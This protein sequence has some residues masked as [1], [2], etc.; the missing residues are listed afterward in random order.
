MS[1]SCHSNAG[2]SLHPNQPQA[3]AAAGVRYLVA[4]YEADAQLA[5]LSMKGIVDVV[6]SEDSDTIP[7]GCRRV[8]WLMGGRDGRSCECFHPL[9]GHVRTQTPPAVT[10]CLQVLFKLD[11]EGKGQEIERANLQACESPSFENWT[12]NMVRGVA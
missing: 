5:Y 1:L 3:L 7:Y 8:R 11:K 2:G 9:T 12:D 4:P 6:I 10:T